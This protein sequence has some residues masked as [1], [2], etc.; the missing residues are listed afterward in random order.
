M[1]AD[2]DAYTEAELNAMTIAVINVLAKSLGYGITAT[3]KADI[4]SE[5]LAV[6]AEK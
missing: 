6:Q 2:T 1:A 3:K 5:F 4:I